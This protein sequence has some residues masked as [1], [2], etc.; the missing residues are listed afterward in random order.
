MANVLIVDDDVDACRPLVR[1]LQFIGHK[2]VFVPDGR[3]ALAMIDEVRPDV[4]LLDV[5]MPGMDGLEVL[6]R[7]RSNPSHRNLPVLV[8]SALSDQAT[9]DTAMERGAQ[10]YLVK[11]KASFSDIQSSIESHVRNGQ[12]SAAPAAE[13]TAR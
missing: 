9:I 12:S 5:M 1:M 6:Q 13:D 2:P 3:T 8:Y 7:V 4:I 11:S 10:A